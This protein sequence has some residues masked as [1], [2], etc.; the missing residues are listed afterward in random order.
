VIP[1]IVMELQRA[2]W[3]LGKVQVRDGGAD[4]DL[5]DADPPAVGTCPPVCKGNGGETVFMH[6]GLFIP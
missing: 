2:V 6:Q 5:V 3:G 4:G 1:G